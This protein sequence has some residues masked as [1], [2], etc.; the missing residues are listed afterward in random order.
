MPE[1]KLHKRGREIFIFFN[2]NTSLET[3]FSELEQMKSLTIEPSFI[4]FAYSSDWKISPV[5][6][7]LDIDKFK[8]LFLTDEAL[9]GVQIQ[10]SNQRIPGTPRS[11]IFEISG[12]ALKQFAKFIN[13]E[14][15]VQLSNEI[16]Q[17]E[18]D[19]FDKRSPSSFPLTYKFPVSFLTENV[20]KSLNLQNRKLD[21]QTSMKRNRLR[22]SHEIYG[23]IKHD[24]SIDQDLIVIGYLDRFTGIKETSFNTFVTLDNERFFNTSVPFHRIRYFKHNGNIVWDR[25]S[26]INLIDGNNS[27]LYC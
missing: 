18:H 5:Q 7:T 14:N 15:T 8:E 13:K 21:D 12:I 20:R 11:P 3:F 1:L 17:Q 10:F 16:F 26:R 24:S 4:H 19:A 6:T 27:I 2:P 23:R 9:P 22:P 25:D